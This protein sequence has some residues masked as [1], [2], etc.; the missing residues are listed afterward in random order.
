MCVCVCVA[1]T[2]SHTRTGPLHEVTEWN[3]RPIDIPIAKWLPVF[4]EGIREYEVGF[5]ASSN[6]S[7][8]R[9]A[10]V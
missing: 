10:H 3:R 8:A 9:V 7:L 1:V 5:S 4:L 6:G 2:P